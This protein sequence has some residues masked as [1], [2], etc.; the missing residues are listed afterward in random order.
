VWLQRLVE[1]TDARLAK[2]TYDQRP[3]HAL[4]PIGSFRAA[5]QRAYPAV[6]AEIKPGRPTEQPRMVDAATV[7]RDYA[8]G[9][10]C[11]ISVLTDPDHFGGQLSNLA[12][13]RAGQLPLLMKDF[14]LDEAQLDAAA[15]WGAT[16]VLVIAR[17]HTEG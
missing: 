10:A 1:A 6:V 11:A 3:Q 13:A 15:A 16:A 5:L 2:G 7:A 14:P 9:G 4:E 12:R 8:E 17:P